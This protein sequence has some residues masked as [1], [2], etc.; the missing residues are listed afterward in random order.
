MSS[1]IIPNILYQIYL[2]RLSWPFYSQEN[3]SICIKIVL[4]MHNLVRL[5]IIIHQN[6]FITYSNSIWIYLSSVKVPQLNTYRSVWPQ[7]DPCSNHNSATFVT[8]FQQLRICCIKFIVPSRSADAL[9]CSPMWTH[10]WSVQKTMAVWSRKWG[11]AN[12]N[13]TPLLLIQEGWHNWLFG[14]EG[15][16][17][18]LCTVVMEVLGVTKCSAVSWDTIVLFLLQ[19]DKAK[20]NGFLQLL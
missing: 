9:N 20:K 7:R 16:G 13:G 10:L 15:L 12:V 17:K 2:W 6:E 19:V 8:V 14:I 11:F 3:I 18:H 1:K 4:N 5:H